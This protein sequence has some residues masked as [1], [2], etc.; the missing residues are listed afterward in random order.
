ML[1]Y[2]D[3][4]GITGT[5]TLIL[6]YYLNVSKVLENRPILIDFL[7]IYGSFGVGFN[8]IIKKTYP[9]LVLEI[10]WIIIAFGSLIR[11]ISKFNKKPQY[12]LPERNLKMKTVY[13]SI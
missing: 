7:N 3:I 12:L 1:E 9:P 8:C 11:N 5:I 2:D 6:A 4:I 13:A 10:A